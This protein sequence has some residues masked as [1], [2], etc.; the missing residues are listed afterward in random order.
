MQI[1]IIFNMKTELRII[2]DC[3]KN[4]CGKCYG[5]NHGYRDPKD[6]VFCSLFT[7]PKAEYNIPLRRDKYVQLER[8]EAC[9]KAE[10]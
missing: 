9:K 7:N 3:Y 6:D 4:T 8:C 2:V 5:A 1:K 10:V